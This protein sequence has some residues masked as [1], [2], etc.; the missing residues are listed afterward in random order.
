MKY[1]IFTSI[2]LFSGC[3]HSVSISQNTT[4]NIHQMINKM[5]T[6]CKS[7]GGE[8]RSTDGYNLG[9]DDANFACSDKDGVWYW[10]RWRDV[11]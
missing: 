8:L 10:I 9:S 2:L 1:A 4:I 11:K 5:Y 3:N 6:V 7:I